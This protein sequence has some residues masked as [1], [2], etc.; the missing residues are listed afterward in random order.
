[1]CSIDPVKVE[2]LLT[3]VVEKDAETFASRI[4]TLAT[5]IGLPTT[6]SAA[7]IPEEG[8]DVILGEGFHPE[9]VK[10]NPRELT[11]ENLREILE[12]IYE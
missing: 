5:Q 12:R 9:R 7:G 4:E 1:M 3:A 11:R 6:L 2:R 10:N 8:I